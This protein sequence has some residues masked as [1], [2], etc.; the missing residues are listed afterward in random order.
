MTR[1]LNDIPTKSENKKMEELFLAIYFNDV[2]KVIDFKNQYPEIYAKK[3]NFQI[4]K[5]TSFN[6][7]NLT[8]FNQT[9]WADHTWNEEIMPLV[10]KNRQRIEQMLDFWSLEFGCK[11]LTREI[12][13]F[14]YCD[15][16][17]CEFPAGHKEWLSYEEWLSVERSGGNITKEFREIDLM[18]MYQAEHFN[19][20]ETKKLLEQGAKSDIDFYD[21]EDS[22]LNSRIADESAFLATTFVVP[23]FEIFEQKGYNQKF[24][25]VDMF[26]RLL[27]FAAHE[28]M[29]HLL[30]EY[31]DKNE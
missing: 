21:D 10:K 25:I 17:Y 6:L 30:A 9:V 28:E 22:S 4:D 5:N 19:F 15:F 29:Y 14:Q 20:A 27:G 3:N 2:K 23:E 16:F 1:Q 7:I 8:F 31:E 26:G 11:K 12:E 18:L 24:D 13:Y